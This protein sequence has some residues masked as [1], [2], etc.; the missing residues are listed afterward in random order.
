MVLVGGSQVKHMT[1]IRKTKTKNK[2][3][4]QQQAREQDYFFGRQH[5]QRNWQNQQEV[6]EWKPQKQQCVYSAMNDGFAAHLGETF[7]D[8]KHLEVHWDAAEWS[9]NTKNRTLA[10]DK[11]QLCI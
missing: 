10:G 4:W 2:G 8:N 7:W 9:Q 11:Q 1:P 5:S 3:T 6:A